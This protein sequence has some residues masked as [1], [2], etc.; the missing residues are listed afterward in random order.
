MSKE[1]LAKLRLKN[2]VCRTWEKGESTWKECRNVFRGCR[3]ACRKAKVYL[4]LNLARDFWDSKKDFRDSTK[5]FSK[6][7]SSKRKVK[8]I[9]LHAD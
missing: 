6:Y 9:G 3:D 7:I 8:E 2:R 4:E 1:L 5:G